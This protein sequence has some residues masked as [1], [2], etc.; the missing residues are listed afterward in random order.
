[1]KTMI[2]FDLD[3][4]LAESKQPI[5]DEMSV[6]LK[7]LLDVA[8]VAVI[9]GGDWPQ[10]EK[11]V[12]GRMQAD[13]K[14]ERLFIM[15]TTGTKLFRFQNGVWNTIYNDAFSPEERDQVL[16]ALNKAWDQAG[17][18]GEQTWGERIEDRGSQI[19][20]SALGQQAPLEA[21]EHWDPKQEKRRQLQAIL[22]T[23]IPDHS[24]NIGGATS[25]DITRKGIDKA[26]GMRRLCDHAGIV[27]ENILFMG[28]AIYPGGN[29]DPVRAAGIDSIKVRDVADTSVA[30][31]AVIACLKA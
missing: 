21:K 14:L 30:I 4:T 24:I 3:G 22:R 26:Y 23:M 2:A 7:N 31:T 18:G 13:A 16:D 20:L 29:D 11:Q 17:F 10:F 28:D 19:T 12:V 8:Q 5:G 25:V 6:L 27:F 9:S 15:P 1:M